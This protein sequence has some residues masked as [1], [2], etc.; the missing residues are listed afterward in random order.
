[1]PTDQTT[2]TTLYVHV[3]ARLHERNLIRLMRGLC[4]AVYLPAKHDL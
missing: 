3:E 2:V 4:E 1:M